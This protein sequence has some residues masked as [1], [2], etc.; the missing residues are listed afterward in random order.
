MFEDYGYIA[1]DKVWY[2]RISRIRKKGRSRGMVEYKMP[3][4]FTD[5]NLSEIN[6]LFD[7]YEKVGED[8]VSFKR[9]SHLIVEVQASK[10]ISH[11]NMQYDVESE[12]FHIDAEEIE[13]IENEF[14]LRH[15]RRRNRNNDSHRDRTKNVE[16][17]GTVR[18]VVLPVSSSG[19]SRRSQRARTVISHLFS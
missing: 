7:V 5:K 15:T 9:S 12:L 3:V 10:I 16:Q 2:G 18:T 8:N 17:S 4:S 1:E 13:A 6:V 14:D 19:D 11:V